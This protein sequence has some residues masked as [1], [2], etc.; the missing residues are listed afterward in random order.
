MTVA[1]LKNNMNYLANLLERD[2]LTTLDKRKIIAMAVQL[3]QNYTIENVR[4]GMNIVFNEIKG[5]N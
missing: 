1:E 5:T 2:N 4:N 3:G